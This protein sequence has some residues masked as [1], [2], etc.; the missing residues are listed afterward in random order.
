MDSSH[1]TAAAYL[2]HGV[3]RALTL[4]ALLAA[5]SSVAVAAPSISGSPATSVTAAHY[6]SF[7][8]SASI[9][10]AGTV[11]FSIANKPSWAQFD[12][13]TGRVYGTP[14]PQTNVGTFANIAIAATAGSQRASLA[15]FSIKV[16]PLPNTPPTL[17]GAPAP[18]VVSG[19]A[20]SFQPK[21]TDPN[22]L[23]VD[24][25]ITNKPSWAT[26]NATTGLLSGTPATTNAGTYS[27]IV[28]TAYDGYSKA[29]LPAFSILV[30]KAASNPLGSPPAG[31]GTTGPAATG[32][33]TL[34][35]M[36]PTQN[37][38]GS[39]LTDLA[40]YHIYYGTTPDLE[41]SITLANGGLT[42]YVLTGL[43]KTTWYFAMTAYDSAGRES[44]RTAVANLSA[45]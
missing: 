34:S 29:V 35:W 38:N 33:A 25:V 6:Y 21:A 28:I 24:F 1:S 37:A 22:G 27:N 41:Q 3:R 7:Q 10:G 17:S 32:S 5:A 15:P 45:Q 39:V 8:P 36:P 31:S 13:H 14:L 43:A 26:F 12:T 30:Q 9:S 42:R 16:L 18:S 40:G 23:T 11:T 4:A 44:D 2:R 20:Y 19:H